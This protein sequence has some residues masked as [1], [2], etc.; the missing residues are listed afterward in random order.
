MG[1]FDKMTPVDE[2]KDFPPSSVM[3][4]KKE[5]NFKVLFSMKEGG[6]G[7]SGIFFATRRSLE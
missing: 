1:E 6:S 7:I 5:N 4:N 2:E 3:E